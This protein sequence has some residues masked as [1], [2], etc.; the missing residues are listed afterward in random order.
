MRPPPPLAG[1][2]HHTTHTHTHPPP[3]ATTLP[4]ASPRH[5][6]TYTRTHPHP[7]PSLT[8]RTYTR[9]DERTALNPPVRSVPHPL[10]P[11]LS[12]PH[13]VPLALVYLRSLT[14]SGRRRRQSC[15]RSL[16]VHTASLSAAPADT[17]AWPYARLAPSVIILVFPERGRTLPPQDD[18]PPCVVTGICSVEFVVTLQGLVL[19]N[20]NQAI[21][22]WDLC[23]LGRPSGL[24]R[25]AC[26]CAP[27]D[28]HSV[29][30]VVVVTLR[31]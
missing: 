26:V 16:S 19:Q 6:H 17:P 22:L 18:D 3:P 9:T 21:D 29:M 11:C 31:S 2:P 25:N 15:G 5:T 28:S 7:P 27:L 23:T 30:V 24:T 14:C 12:L 20:Q 4:L 1:T 13:L 10:P 8:W